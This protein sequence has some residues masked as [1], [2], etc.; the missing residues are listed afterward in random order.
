M[1]KNSKMLSHFRT[2]AE[3]LLSTT[4]LILVNK[5]IHLHKK[6]NWC[7]RTWAIRV[8]SSE[9]KDHSES[10]T[11]RFDEKIKVLCKFS[12]AFFVVYSQLRFLNLTQLF[13]HNK[14]SLYYNFVWK[15]D[16][17]FSLF[18]HVLIFVQW[19]HEKFDDKFLFFC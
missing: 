17:F 13:D 3:Q 6:E 1:M 9:P 8:S 7:L 2:M 5:L 16:D 10:C 14:C 11:T 4:L 18:K 12:F 19:F 15:F